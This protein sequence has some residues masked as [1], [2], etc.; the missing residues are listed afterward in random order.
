MPLTAYV[1][2]SK[3]FFRKFLLTIL[4]KTSSCRIC[5]THTF[6]FR[7]VVKNLFAILNYR[8]FQTVRALSAVDRCVQMRVFKHG[9]DKEYFIKDTEDTD[10]LA[11]TSSKVM[12]LGFG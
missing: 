6:L 2:V 9:H 12:L 8:L 11:F 7:L 3:T 10:F 5:V 4:T 1:Q